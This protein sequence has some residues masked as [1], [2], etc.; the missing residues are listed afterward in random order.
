MLP[1]LSHCL[2][3]DAPRQL[4]PDP[5]RKIPTLR[6]PF[7]RE[8][9]ISLTRETFIQLD[10]RPSQ[11]GFAA[12]EFDD[13][14]DYV[15]PVTQVLEPIWQMDPGLPERL[16]AAALGPEVVELRVVAVERDAKPDGE[17]TFQRRAVEAGHVRHLRVCYRRAYPLQQTRTVEYLLRQRHV[18]G[19]VAG[20]KRQPA[21]GVAQWDARQ[22]MQIIVHN[23]C[24]DVLA[25]DVDD[26][27]AGQA[28]EHQHA[29]HPLLVVVRT[30]NLPQLLDVEREARHHDDRLGGARIRDHP[31]RQRVELRL[32][33]RE[34]PELLWRARLRHI[35]RR[36]LCGD[37]AVTPAP[38]AKIIR[39]APT[40][41]RRALVNIP[42]PLS[43]HQETVMNPSS[44]HDLLRGDQTCLLFGDGDAG[45]CAGVEGQEVGL[46][47]VGKDH[48]VLR[49][50]ADD[51]QLLAGPDVAPH[52]STFIVT[53][54]CTF[55]AGDI[56][57]SS[58][59]TS[60]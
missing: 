21:A 45:D 53:R 30:G 51:L 15:V 29:K 31:P 32:Q 10:G 7:I 54:L 44:L 46:D 33:S 52:Y 57:R 22:E 39:E 48:T 36:R 14:L 28:Q 55:P 1:G 11:P 6:R 58:P 18:G 59:F 12:L 60:S 49:H 38:W 20:E 2:E 25:R 19:V 42:G 23:G 47:A 3:L 5:T 9:R 13:G 41:R 43:A 17:T 4:V 56:R 24:R 40:S 8:N 27:G 50:L 35:N 26:M 16:A 37:H 34:A